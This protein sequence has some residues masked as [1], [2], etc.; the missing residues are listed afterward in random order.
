MAITKFSRG[1]VL[2]GD[3][4]DGAPVFKNADTALRQHLAQLAKAGRTP[5]LVKLGQEGAHLRLD[6]ALPP[7]P[8]AIY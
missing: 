4:I 8:N 5:F 6:K 1:M 2:R 7:A 3:L